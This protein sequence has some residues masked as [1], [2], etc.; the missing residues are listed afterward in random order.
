MKKIFLFATALLFTALLSAQAPQEMN[1]QAVVRDNSGNALANATPVKLRFTIHDGSQSGTAV[2]TETIN[3]STNQFGLVNVQ[4]GST[5]NLGV[6][7]WGSGAK[8][9]QVE[10]DV[11]NSGTFTD[12]GVSQLISV[13]YALYAANGGGGGAT[14]ENGACVWI[15]RTIGK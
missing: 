2:Y 4:I 1:Y 10:T 14:I 3:T 9:L 11:N 13:P 15:K 7:S 5:Q 12:M 6:V 8:Y